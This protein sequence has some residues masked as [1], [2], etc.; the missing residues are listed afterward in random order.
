M[1]L[2]VLVL[3][4]ERVADSVLGGQ[5]LSAASHSTEQHPAGRRDDAL[6][7][8]RHE[9]AASRLTGFGGL[10]EAPSLPRPGDLTPQ[11]PEHDRKSDRSHE[12]HGRR[13]PVQPRRRQARRQL[14]PRLSRWSSS[15]EV[16]SNDQPVRQTTADR[17]AGQESCKGSTQPND[18]RCDDD[19]PA[20]GDDDTVDVAARST[21]FGHASSAARSHSGSRPAGAEGPTSCSRRISS[22]DERAAPNASTG[23][24]NGPATISA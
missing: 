14:A 5:H 21:L 18:G 24:A 7:G 16:T 2:A 11:P 1:P 9:V 10:A 20:D 3:L 8:E 4:R 22:I 19:D 13:R 12:H 15:S 17:A 6:H 23:S